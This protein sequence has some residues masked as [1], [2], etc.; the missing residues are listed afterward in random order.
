MLGTTRPPERPAP[1]TRYPGQI[2][3]VEDMLKGIRP[4]LPPDF[5]R[6]GGTFK[7]NRTVAESPKPDGLL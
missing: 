4:K 2:L 6:G 7:R 5:T 1:R 3:T